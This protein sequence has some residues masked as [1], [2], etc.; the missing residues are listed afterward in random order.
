[1]ILSYK[2]YTFFSVQANILDKDLEKMK[3]KDSKKRIIKVHPENRRMDVDNDGTSDVSLFH[4]IL[5]LL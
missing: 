2:N 1:M 4:I 5:I 3:I